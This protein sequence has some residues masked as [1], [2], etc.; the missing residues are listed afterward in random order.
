MSGLEVEVELEL[1]ILETHWGGVR[2]KE[3]V[4]P[5]GR[6]TVWVREVGL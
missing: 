3:Q 5:V 4:R 6:K 2:V 1:E